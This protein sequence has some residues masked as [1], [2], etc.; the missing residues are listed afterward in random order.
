MVPKRPDGC[1]SST[2]AALTPDAPLGPLG[3]PRPAGRS[4]ILV[5]TRSAP[6]R[7]VPHTQSSFPLLIVGSTSSPT[8]LPQSF[9]TTLIPDR[10]PLINPRAPQSAP[11]AHA[12]YASTLRIRAA[13]PIVRVA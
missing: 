6:R 13:F 1:S 2:A 12:S 11:Y 9:L 3:P 7:H 5:S 4:L 8:F 10:R